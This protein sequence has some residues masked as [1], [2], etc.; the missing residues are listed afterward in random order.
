MT[1]EEFNALSAEQVRAV[2]SPCVNIPQWV[3]AVSSARPF[4]S[5]D[6]AV[7]FATQASS[8]WQSAAVGGALAQHP[9]IGER[10]TGESKEA[11][12]SRAEQASLGLEQQATQAL[13]AGNQQYEQRFNRVFLIRAKGRTPAE[14]L[15][16]LQRRLHNSDQQEWQET[17]EQLQQ[18]TVLRFKELFN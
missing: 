14:I 17:A 1:L 7:D 4:N 2:L 15:E 9:R 8:G 5:V 18:I 3:N 10:M 12:L 11:A 6:D 13:L 16:H